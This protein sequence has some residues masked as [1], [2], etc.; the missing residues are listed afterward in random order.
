MTIKKTIDYKSYMECVNDIVNAFF[1]E[2][3]R[4]APHMGRIVLQSIFVDYFV[5]DFEEANGKE[6]DE[7]IEFIIG[8]ETIS[9]E[10]KH[11]LRDFSLTE[12]NFSS[13]YSDAMEIVEYRKSS[14]MQGV[15][16][17]GSIVEEIMSPDNLAKIYETSER[18][19]KIA[20]ED[21]DNVT[22]LFPNQGA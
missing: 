22:P 1:D 15:S 8:N 18:L 5:S 6:G 13:A 11:A 2:E 9:E 16:M 12:L 10:I 14:L 19:K 20:L 17:F 4:Y 7:L 21:K 3:G